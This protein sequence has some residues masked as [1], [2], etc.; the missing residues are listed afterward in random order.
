LARA[1]AFTKGC[2]GGGMMNDPV[3]CWWSGGITSAVACKKAI[4]LFGVDNCLLLM[5]DTFN[6]DLDT[7]RFKDDC[8][9]WYGK[10][11]QTISAIPKYYRSIQ[12]VWYKYLSLNVAHGAICSAE[13]KRKVRIEWQKNNRYSYQVFGFEF[14]KKE[15]NRALSMAMNYPESLAIFPLLLYGYE[16]ERCIEIVTDSGIVIPRA[17]QSGFK[18]NNCLKTGCVQAGIG[19]WQKMK[20]EY[21]VRLYNMAMIEHELTD[22]KGEPV[23]ILRDQSNEAKETGNFQVFLVKHPDYPHLK[24][25]DDMP[26]CKVEPL[27]ECNGFC[28]LDDLNPVNKTHELLNLGA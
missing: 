14:T 13:L 17:Y 27:I 28:G 22:L 25:I 24:C 1:I 2:W 26:E 15:M 3:V 9:S 18:N 4:E 6:E 7:Y 20:R 12:D 23:T 21:L 5:I 8:S 10:D 19:Y 11:I 16:K